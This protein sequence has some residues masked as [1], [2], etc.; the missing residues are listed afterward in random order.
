[1]A[2]EHRAISRGNQAGELAAFPQWFSFAEE[3]LFALALHETEPHV[4]NN[5]T[6]VWAGLF[7]IIPM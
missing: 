4:G 5:A 6:K 3:I 7:P 1:M 2:I